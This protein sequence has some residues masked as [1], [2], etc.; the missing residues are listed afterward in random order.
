MGKIG[1][2]QQQQPQG[3]KRPNALIRER[4]DG[5]QENPL[6]WFIINFKLI[7]IIYFSKICLQL[8]TEP[9]STIC[10]H[11]FCRNC[12][13]QSIQHNPQCPICDSNL[14]LK[15]PKTICPNYT[16]ATMVEQR[17]REVSS[18]S[19]V[20]TLS[21]GSPTASAE[22]ILQ[23]IQEQPL[24]LNALHRIS[25]ALKKRKLELELNDQQ[26]R[27]VLLHDFLDRMIDKRESSV[28]QIQVE[29]E[30]LKQD[31]QRVLVCFLF[32]NLKLI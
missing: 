9:Y 30:L 19:S 10:G 15:R 1:Q 28:K 26:V 29:L 23:L 31:K 20:A 6:N 2:S 12:I 13:V 32:S 7:Q 4:V 17:Q 25:E 27:N 16:V 21:A 18:S 8:F 11:T 3:R 14:D 22:S 24:N 5:E